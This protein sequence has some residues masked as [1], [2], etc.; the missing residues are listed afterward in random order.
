[1]GIDLLSHADVVSRCVE[2]D[3]VT[4]CRVSGHDYTDAPT[5]IRQD[6]RYDR[7]G[8]A[9]IPTGEWSKFEFCNRCGERRWLCRVD[10]PEYPE[11]C[12]DWSTL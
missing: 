7:A 8:R 9:E 10:P 11:P 12:E 6:M 4:I 5:A 2:G 3:A 1:M